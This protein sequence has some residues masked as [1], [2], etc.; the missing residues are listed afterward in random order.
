M[1]RA[2]GPHGLR[3]V[4]NPEGQ[5]IA[6]SATRL[7]AACLAVLRAERVR[8]ALVSLTLLSRPRMAAMNRAHLGT[9]GA[10]DVIAFGFRD[11]Q[12]AVI[13]DVYLCPMVARANATRFGVSVREELLRLAV[14]GTLHALGHDHPVGEARVRSPMWRRQE[15]LLTR[16]LGT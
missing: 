8:H 3:V 11:P 16:V 10:T 13:G 1:T 5:R 4:V 14:H 7:R 15:R 12:G 6:V 2:S 9:P